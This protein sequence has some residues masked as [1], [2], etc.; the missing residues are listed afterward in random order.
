MKIRV[1]YVKCNDF[2]ILGPISALLVTEGK[3]IGIAGNDNSTHCLRI[4]EL[5]C[6]N[7]FYS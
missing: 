3:L 6:L 7:D 4:W 1:P 2:A 5:D